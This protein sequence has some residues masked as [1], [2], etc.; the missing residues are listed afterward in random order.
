M[1]F[2]QTFGQMNNFTIVHNFWYKYSTVVYFNER[3]KTDEWR[4][5][6]KFNL[7]LSNVQSNAYSCLLEYC[8]CLPRVGRIYFI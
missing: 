3:V 7:F 4:T 6:I 1:Q 5:C 2:T 8:K